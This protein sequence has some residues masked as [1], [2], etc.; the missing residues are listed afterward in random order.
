MANQYDSLIVEAAH[1]YG[2][3]PALMKAMMHTESSYDPNARSPVGAMGLMQLMP[4]TAKRFGVKDPFDPAQNIEGAAKYIKYLTKMFN[5]NPTKIIAAYNAGEG[6]VRKYGGIPPFAETQDYVKKVTGR[7]GGGNVS[8]SPQPQSRAMLARQ[9]IFGGR[10]FSVTSNFGNRKAPVAGASTF[11]NGIDL[12]APK[13]TPIYA[14]EDG[15]IGGNQT[16]EGGNQMWLKGSSGYRFGFAH[17]DRYAVP[18]GSQVRKG[19]LIGYTGDSGIGTGAHLHFT[20]TD[21]RGQKINPA[22]FTLN[23][24]GQTQPLGQYNSIEEA[25]AAQKQ[26]A[27]IGQ[28]GSID[29]ALAAQKQ[30]QPIGKFSSIDEALA[31]Q[32]QAEPLGKYASI[33]EAIA[34]QKPVGQYGSIDEALGA[35]TT[36]QPQVGQFGSID[37]A[38]KHVAGG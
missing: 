33:D 22:D 29:E 26:A 35:Q 12:G 11:H 16:K 3:N 19:Q 28:F 38:L 1:R 4:A 10:D 6:N 34:A 32:R 37:E 14:A 24:G 25:L 18:L 31:A 23:G 20:V 21:P 13:G 8:A 7:L 5:G 36:P 15:V 17:L 30:S 2:V 9:V 27:P